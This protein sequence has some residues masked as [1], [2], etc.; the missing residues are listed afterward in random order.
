VPQL[1]TGQTLQEGR[2]PL[3]VLLAED[4]PVNQR[5]AARLLDKR[6][7]VVVLA[8]N[9]ALALEALEQQSFDL[10]LMD[11]QMPVMDGVQATAAIR[12][13]ERIT[14][15]HIPIIAMTAHAMEGDRERFLGNGMDGYISKPV[16]PREL[17]EVIES[18]L[19]LNAALV[20]GGPDAE[21]KL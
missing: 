14:G 2:A 18:L 9:G 20:G 16:Q 7:H 4:N 12:Q 5:V 19:G 15:T 3:R 6:G 1:V 8:G 17:F 21:P 13:R 11:V 10:I